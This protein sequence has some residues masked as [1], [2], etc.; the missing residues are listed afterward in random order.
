M[1][2]MSPPQLHNR[3][4][5]WKGQ[6]T[7]AAAGKTCFKA[8]EALSL[9]GDSS[10]EDNFFHGDQGNDKVGIFRFRDPVYMHRQS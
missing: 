9:E 7:R 4:E 6:V 1:V 10:K 3:Y 2:I 5:A 8:K